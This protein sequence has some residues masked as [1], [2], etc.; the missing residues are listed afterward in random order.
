MSQSE[1]TG[2]LLNLVIFS[3]DRAIQL[4]G[5]LKSLQENAD[6]FF[7]RIAVLYRADR[8]EHIK[9][10]E[11]LKKEWKNVHF[12]Q[13]N[14]FH[15]FRNLLL[16]KSLSSDF[17]FTCF[18]VDDNLLFKNIAA[19][20]KKIYSSFKDDTAAF[21]LR[22]GLNC[23]YSHPANLH[24]QLKNFKI[25]EDEFLKW[26]WREQD[27]GDFKYPLALDGHIFSTKKILPIIKAV[28]F[29]NPN[30][31]ESVL[32]HSLNQIPPCMQSFKYSRLVGLPV[33]LVNSG[34]K[35]FYG[36]EYFYDT[37][38]LCAKYLDGWRIDIKKIDYENV[39]SAH[40]ELKLEFIRK[41]N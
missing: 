6:S 2:H 1:N 10:Y 40:C 25:S 33:N 27:A 7:D 8:K 23:T 34:G 3:K 9:S 18:M 36:K 17:I 29:N 15:N 19:E 37:D 41:K 38:E 14:I 24:F 31:L 12:F 13:E 32:Q 11:L 21:S 16:K 5:L 35:N 22:L 28:S 20:K 39:N 4:D 30:S 26:D